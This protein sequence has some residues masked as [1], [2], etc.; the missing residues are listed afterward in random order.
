M[1]GLRSDDDIVTPLG[2]TAP[3]PT[4]I[5]RV[6]ACG[7]FAHAARDNPGRFA[8]TK[9]FAAADHVN[10]SRPATGVCR[11]CTAL[12][13]VPVEPIA[14]ILERLGVTTVRPAA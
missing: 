4:G 1:H 7:T 8:H 2:R 10:P 13:G 12:L 3:N 11:S 6:T 14:D 5:H 9:F